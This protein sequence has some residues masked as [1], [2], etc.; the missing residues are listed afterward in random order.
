[1]HARITELNKANNKARV[2]AGYCWD[3]VSRRF[4]DQPDIVISEHAYAKKW[5]LGSD[6]SLWVMAPNSVDEVGC[7]HTCQGLELDYVGVIIG[8]D[9]VYR[10]GRIVSDATKRASSDQ[11]VKGLKSMLKADSASAL[12]LSDA[13][14]KNTYRTLM[15]RGMKGCYVYCT[16]PALAGHL[17]SGLGPAL[18]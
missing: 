8:P 2:V 17:K 9:L 13:I 3:W 7:I 18:V 16:D 14:V 12:A 6:G 15:T 11:S 5:N 10:D 1:M 4:P